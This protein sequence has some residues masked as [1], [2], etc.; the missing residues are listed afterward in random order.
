MKK[1]LLFSFA[2]FGVFTATEAQCDS[3]SS[4]SPLAFC[5]GSTVELEATATAAVL[6]YTLI[7][8]DAWGDGW[9]GNAVDVLV[10]GVAVLEGQTFATGF[11]AEA[12]FSAY[13]GVQVVLQVKFLLKS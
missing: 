12:T 6:T 7:M 2:L 4:A 13:T 11:G 10:N 8:T 9:N 3:P 1:L 5:G